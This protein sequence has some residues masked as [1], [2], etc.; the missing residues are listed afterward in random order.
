MELEILLSQIRAAFSYLFDE[1]DFRL[2]YLD[3]KL[4]QPDTALI[5]LTSPYCHIAFDWELGVLTPLIGPAS[6]IFGQDTKV[7]GVD[8]WYNLERIIDFMQKRPFRWPAAHEVPQSAE[9]L[10][11]WAN[12]LQPISFQVLR[13]FANQDVVRTWDTAFVSYTMTQIKLRFS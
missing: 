13:S 1:Y 3:P 9:L 4:G 6:S 7:D 12:A 10:A 2:V 8:Q 5:G 11:G